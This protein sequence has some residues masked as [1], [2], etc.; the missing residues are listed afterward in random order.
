MVFGSPVLM[1]LRPERASATRPLLAELVEVPA[2]LAELVVM[3]ATLVVLV[4][5]P[6]TVVLLVPSD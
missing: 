5:T 1:L 3:P 2:A 4:V 6:P